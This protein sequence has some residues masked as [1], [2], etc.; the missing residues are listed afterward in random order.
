MG[1]YRFEEDGQFRMQLQKSPF[2]SMEE[3][4]R[5]A[6]ELKEDLP[7]VRVSVKFGAEG[8]IVDLISVEKDRETVI[9][10]TCAG[11]D[12]VI[13]DLDRETLK[14]LKESIEYAIEE[15]EED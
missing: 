12:D 3:T 13:W 4:K 11:Y 7:E 9:S 10:T 6:M 1:K 14:L 5:M 8:V 15:K 2:D